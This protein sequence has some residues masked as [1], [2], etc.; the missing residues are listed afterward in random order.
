MFI[1]T[2]MNL[3]S[4]M[5][6]KY[7]YEIYSIHYYILIYNYQKIN[8]KDIYYGEYIFPLLKKTLKNKENPK[9][10]EYKMIN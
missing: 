5:I 4:F 8:K 2:P 7:K 9:T 6:N 3:G 1:R 10:Y